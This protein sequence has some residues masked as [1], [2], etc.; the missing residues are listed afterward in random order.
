MDLAVQPIADLAF[1]LVDL[2]EPALP[3]LDEVGRHELGDGIAERTFNAV[4]AEATVQR[5]LDRLHTSPRKRAPGFISS[6]A[7]IASLSWESNYVRCAARDRLAQPRLLRRL[8]PA[9]GVVVD[10]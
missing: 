8:Q 7:S 5:L 9:I 4:N 2:G 1:D 3:D 10:E 6:K